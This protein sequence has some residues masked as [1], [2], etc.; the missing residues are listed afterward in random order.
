MVWAL[1]VS[2]IL[3]MER[4]ENVYGLYMVVK[5]DL[6]IRW[7]RSELAPSRLA[8]R[9]YM[10]AKIQPAPPAKLFD[11]ACSHFSPKKGNT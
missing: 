7:C 2:I 1:L 4:T 11:L 5:K 9:V 10:E 6:Y 8:K 3:V